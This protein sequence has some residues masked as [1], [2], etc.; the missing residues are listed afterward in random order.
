MAKE[1]RIPVNFNKGGYVLNGLVETR[2]AVEAVC[3][4]LLGLLI[5]QILP[6]KNIVLSIV[7]HLL[8]IAGFA[9]VGFVGVRGEPFSVFFINYMRWRRIRRKPY[10]YNPNGETFSGSPTKMI[11][12][13]QDAGDALADVLDAMKAKFQKEKP[14]YIEG[15][16]FR[17]QEDPLV[18]R[19]RNIEEQKK[20]R[21]EEEAREQQDQTDVSPDIDV[22]ALMNELGFQTSAEGGDTDGQT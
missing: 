9:I 19:L 17:F 7:L 14:E 6:L 20:E 10:I 4:A 11:F 15:R 3:G 21:E 13:E 12:E 1:Y 8:F 22:D 5:C 2:K 16:T 18:E